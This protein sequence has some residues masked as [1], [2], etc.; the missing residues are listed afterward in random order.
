LILSPTTPR[1]YAGQTSFSICRYYVLVPRIFRSVQKMW[2]PRSRSLR[3]GYTWWSRGESNSRPK[4]LIISRYTSLGNTL[5]LLKPATRVILQAADL[6]GYASV[7]LQIKKP[8]RQ[9]SSF[10]RMQV[11]KQH[12]RKRFL[13]SL[14]LFWQLKFVYR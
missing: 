12:P 9:H 3:T 2:L 10:R 14:Q 7:I 6:I 11:R 1:G 4:R 5:V 13:L 8:E